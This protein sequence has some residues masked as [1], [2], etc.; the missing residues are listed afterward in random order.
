MLYIYIFINFSILFKFSTEPFI[1][2]KN[3]DVKPDKGNGVVV[4]NRADYLEGILNIINDKHKFKELD[5]DPTIIREGKLQRFH[6]ELKVIPISTTRDLC[7]HTHFRPITSNDH[8][9]IHCFMIKFCTSTSIS[10]TK[11]LL[12]LWL[13][14]CQ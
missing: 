9:C 12:H 3:Y 7:T 8:L 11:E 5:S 2:F 4:L 14:P 1:R 6:R 13:H 10:C